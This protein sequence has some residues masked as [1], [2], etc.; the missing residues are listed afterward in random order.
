MMKSINQNLLPSRSEIPY[1]IKPSAWLRLHCKHS[2]Q[3]LWAEQCLEVRAA[4]CAHRHTRLTTTTLKEPTGHRARLS[5]AARAE[6][7]KQSPVVNFRRESTCLGSTAVFQPGPSHPAA[8]REPGPWQPHPAATPAPGKGRGPARGAPCAAPSKPLKA[9][10]SP[11][12]RQRPARSEG[13]GFSFKK[14]EDGDARMHT[15]GDCEVRGG[16]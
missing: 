4:N 6:K 16:G 13:K 12:T 10:R 1:F 15:R 2:P 9:T 14:K 5:C 11:G 8:T 3:V 7:H